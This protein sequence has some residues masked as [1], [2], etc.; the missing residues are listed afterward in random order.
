MSLVNAPVKIV[1]TWTY[2]PFDFALVSYFNHEIG[3]N[4]RATTQS[5]LGFSTSLGVLAMSLNDII[6][7]FR[8]N[9]DI[10]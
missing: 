5:G 2:I 1:H 3:S 6:K 10:L 8:G 9:G 7:V 4:V